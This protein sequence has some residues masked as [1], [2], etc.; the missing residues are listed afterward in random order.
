MSVAE[1]IKARLDLVA[2]ISESVSLKKA[3]RNYKAN[4]P[5]HQERTPSFIV[6][7]DTQTWRCFGACG[8]GGDIFAFAMKMHGWDFGEAL[9]N[10]AQR[11]GVELAPSTPEQ[12]ERA[13]ASERLLGLLDQTARFFHDQLLH[14]PAAENARAYVQ[15]RG[16]SEATVQTFLLGYAPGGWHALLNHLGKLGYAQDDLIAAGVAI[17]NDEGR[18]YDRFRERLVIPIRDGRGRVVGFGA[19]AL[20]PGDEPKYLNSPQTPLFD[21]SSTLF[22]LDLARRE[23][24]ERETAVIVEGY[25][26]AM[27]AHQAGFRNVVAQMGT[28]LTEPQLQTLRKYASRLILA[29]D[30]DAA[31]VSATMRGLDVARQ[32]LDEG[33]VA[34]F[35][36]DGSMRKAARLG[37]D[38]RVISLPEG[39]DPDDLIRENPEAWRQLC[40]HAEPVADY[41][42]RVGTANLD[43]RAASSFDK[44]KIARA[45]LP[46]LMATESDLHKE[47]N[48]QKL[49]LALHLSERRLMEIAL[50]SRAATARPQPTSARIRQKH[51]TAAMGRAALDRPKR[52]AS[53]QAQSAPPPF[54]DDFAPPPEDLAGADALPTTAVRAHLRPV[55]ASAQERYC[56]SA[57]LRQPEL[58]YQANRALRQVADEAAQAVTDGQRQAAVRVALGPLEPQ[59]FR[60]AAY[61][62]I[63]RALLAA[64]AQDDTDPLEYVRASLGEPLCRQVDELRA[65][66]PLDAFQA[67]LP[68]PLRAELPSVLKQQQREGR[69]LAG[70]ETDL[71][72]KVLYLRRE[73]LRRANE[74]LYFLLQEVHDLTENAYQATL[75]ANNSV[76]I[77]HLDRELQRRAQLVHDR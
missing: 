59:D 1:E 69:P 54:D 18:V 6:F 16:L 7:P 11:A 36:P 64:L 56:L 49:A 50:E 34:L 68:G 19:R 48:V 2:Y 53:P 32:T 25:M 77:V 37:I 13:A 60:D 44:E 70:P 22:A 71:V 10:L 61:Q 33:G 17:R 72:E 20:K 8:E 41:V 35:G 5:F 15:K 52:P 62:A 30:P 57:L 75:H 66:P 4:C 65:T 21:K 45:L 28:A 23:I 29:L 67:A 24:R 51:P 38:L 74:E 76:A 39:Q 73:R 47:A 40:E 42:I 14:A 63:A 27:Q 43:P 9:R 58:I 12:A 31:G 26:D 55:L 46:I 3:G